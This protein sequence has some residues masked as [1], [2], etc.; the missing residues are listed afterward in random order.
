VWTETEIWKLNLFTKT[1]LRQVSTMSQLDEFDK[2]DDF[3]VEQWQVLYESSDIEQAK[4]RGGDAE[5]EGQCSKDAKMP[6]V[7]L[8][9]LCLLPNT[10]V[11]SIR[12]S[13]SIENTATLKGKDKMEK[14]R[15]ERLGKGG[16]ILT[17]T[18]QA[19]Q[20]V[21][22]LMNQMTYQKDNSF[23]VE[24]V[25]KVDRDKK[26]ESQTFTIRHMT[27]KVA[28]KPRMSERET[29]ESAVGTTAI[30]ARN[31]V[32]MEKEETEDHIKEE[33]CGAVKAVGRK[34]DA[35]IVTSSEEKKVLLRKE[36]SF[37]CPSGASIVVTPEK[38]KMPSKEP[39]PDMVGPTV[40]AHL[41]QKETNETR[42]T[43]IVSDPKK[44]VE[45]NDNNRGPLVLP[46]GLR[47]STKTEKE[48]KDYF[49]KVH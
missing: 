49:D 35:K 31:M 2:M 34:K 26:Q 16:H 4:M 3:S 45:K 44:V 18:E 19:R 23:V 7:P 29:T 10:V 40:Q 5:I 24:R 43:T 13:R 48:I 28:K 21:I 32:K 36:V 20:D 14:N 33:E 17:T 1:R 27:G 38:Q 22:L 6:M 15:L 41:S 30:E 37:N 46:P 47:K 11:A 25:I 9:S 8:K 42:Y 12:V 39:L